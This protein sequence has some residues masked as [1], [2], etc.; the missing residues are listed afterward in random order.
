LYQS[1]VN[2]PPIYLKWNFDIWPVESRQLTP[3]DIMQ[4]CITMHC[5]DG[6]HHV[7]AEQ[8]DSESVGNWCRLYAKLIT[9]PLPIDRERRRRLL[10]HIAAASMAA[11]LLR[12]MDRRVE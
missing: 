2:R 7:V 8:N 5:T 9:Q 1:L 4:K 6:A 12:V 10:C 3:D 11:V